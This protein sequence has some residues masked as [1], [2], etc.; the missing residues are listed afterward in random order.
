MYLFDSYAWIEYL[1]GTKQGNKVKKI[2]DKNNPIITLEPNIAEVY[3]WCLKHDKHF[4]EILPII[5][6]ISEIHQINLHHWLIAIKLR[7][8]KRKSMKDFGLIDA[9]LLAKQTENK[10]TIVTGDKHFR[11][12]KNVIFL[13]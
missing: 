10:G 7:L 5:T 6:S 4:E 11:N 2:I 12:T 1:L 3:N 8:E 9:L 13:Y